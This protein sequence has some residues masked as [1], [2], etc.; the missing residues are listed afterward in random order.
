[1]GLTR[2]PNDK[3]VTVPNVDEVVFAVPALD[4]SDAAE[5]LSYSPDVLVDAFD[6]ALEVQKGRNKALS[7]KAPIFIAL[8]ESADGDLVAS[9]LRSKAQWTTV[10]PMGSIRRLAAA[11]GESFVE[12]RQRVHRE[13]AQLQGLDVHE[14]DVEFIIKGLA[15]AGK[16]KGSAQE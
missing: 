13:F 3:W 11:R 1:V 4:G 10:I 15:R 16:D 8:D 14:V 7:H 2:H 9:G 6:R 12:F 5:V